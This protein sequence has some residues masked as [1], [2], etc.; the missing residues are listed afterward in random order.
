MNFTVLYADFLLLT[1]CATELE[2]IGKPRLQTFVTCG[3]HWGAVDPRKP[4]DGEG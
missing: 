3:S 2:K 4:F 1:I